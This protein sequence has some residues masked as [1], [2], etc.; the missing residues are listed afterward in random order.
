M[1]PSRLSDIRWTA[2]GW[3]RRVERRDESTG[4]RGAMEASRRARHPE[5]DQVP[6]VNHPGNG[7]HGDLKDTT[8]RRRRA[9]ERTME[10]ASALNRA[11]FGGASQQQQVCCSSSSSLLLLSRLLHFYSSFTGGVCTKHLNMCFKGKRVQPRACVCACTWVIS[12]PCRVFG[13]F[14]ER[15]P[16]WR[17]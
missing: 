8:G 5:R 6:P 4:G 10:T 2:G 16:N 17:L 3:R 7:R 11:C 12:S 15:V 1:T 14:P 13:L 9:G